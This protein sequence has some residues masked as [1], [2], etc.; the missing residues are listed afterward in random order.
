MSSSDKQ[1]LVVIALCVLS[2]LAYVL[3]LVEHFNG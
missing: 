2:I 3:L 1:L